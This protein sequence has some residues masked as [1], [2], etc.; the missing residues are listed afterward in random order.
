MGKVPLYFKP[1]YEAKNDTPYVVN[2]IREDI[3]GG[4]TSSYCEKETENFTGTTDSKVSPEVKS[5]EGFTSPSKYTVTI[6]VPGIDKV[7]T[8]MSATATIVIDEKEDALLV[9]VDAIQTVEGKACVT[10]V[11]GETQEIVPVTLGLVNNTEAEILEGISEGDIVVVTEKS[12]F[13]MM[14]DMM[15]QG[16][17]QGQ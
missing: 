7:K 8:S 1:V 12:E 14:V 4:F 11:R 9:P 3:D 16:V 6:S 2:H 13:Q 17:Q 15:Q 10:V 5:Y